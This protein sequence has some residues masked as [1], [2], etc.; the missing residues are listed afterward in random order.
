MID[1][2]SFKTKLRAFLLNNIVTVVFIF[3]IVL[4]LSVSTNLTFDFLMNELIARF[5]RNGFLVLSLI[6]PVI[7]GLG[8]NF[9]IVVGALAGML[10]LIVVRYFNL[11]GISGLMLSFLIALPLAMLFGFAT[12]KLYNKTRGQEMIASYIV[13]FFANGL[14]QFIVLFALGV[15]IPLSKGHVMVKPDGVG[16]RSTFDMGPH[17]LSRTFNPETQTPGLRYALDWI[18]RAPFLPMLI[19]FG[20]CFLVFLVVRRMLAQKNPALKQSKSWAFILSCSLCVALIILGVYGLLVPDNFLSGIREIPVVTGIVILAL[21]LF[22]QYFTKTKL[23][24][25][26]RSVGF[27]QHIA[28]VSGINVDRTRIIATMISTVLAS[29]G[30]IIYL[31]NMGTV[32]TYTS[33]MQIGMFAVAALLVGGATKAKANIKNALL[34][35]VLFNAM[36]IVSPDIGRLFSGDEGVGEYTRSFM[37]YGVISLALWLYAWKTL[38]AEKNKE[39]QYAWMDDEPDT[40]TPESKE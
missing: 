8:L 17:P 20:I 10:S 33:H 16:L 37:V 6:I 14:Y 22:T 12:G 15:I 1:D 32:S 38:K 35:L 3:I 23:G 26:C 21:C 39:L 24:Q 25:D 9:G 13:G 11:G 5:F 31:Q 7:A 36:F 27:D 2:S 34:G 28:E 40:K 18:W 4:G 19:A 29:W 30:M